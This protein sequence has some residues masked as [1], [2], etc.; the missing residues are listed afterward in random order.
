MIKA[1]FG[2][3]KREKQTLKLMENSM[4]FN[5]RRSIINGRKAESLP[6]A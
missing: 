4:G 6:P 2:H 1:P 3:S 5:K